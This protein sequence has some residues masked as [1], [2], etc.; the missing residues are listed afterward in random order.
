MIKLTSMLGIFV[1]M[2]VEEEKWLDRFDEFITFDNLFLT[3]INELSLLVVELHL[4]PVFGI[5]LD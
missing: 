4:N 2:I 5:S 1:Q 3:D